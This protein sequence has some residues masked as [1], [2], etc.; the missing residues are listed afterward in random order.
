MSETGAAGADVL[1][2]GGTH[3]QRRGSAGWTRGEARGRLLGF[4]QR[5]RRP[6]GW[7]AVGLAVVAWL[8][9]R[10]YGDRTPPTPR[11]QVS[12]DRSAESEPLWS[13]GR[14]GRPGSPATLSVAT[15]LSVPDL[16]PGDPQVSPL[17]L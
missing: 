12:Q 2:G 8:G 3:R 14:D 4:V 6:A 10:W 7:L 5:H 15:Q 16:R 17:G 9:V 1:E 13:P 11:V